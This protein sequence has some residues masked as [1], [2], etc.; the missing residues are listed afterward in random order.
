MTLP[1][2]LSSDR[3]SHDVSHCAG[4]PHAA[5][6]SEHGTHVVSV[7][8]AQPGRPIPGFAPNA[9]ARIFSFYRQG[10]DGQLLP[11]S[12]AGLALAIDSAVT[13]G[14]LRPTRACLRLAERPEWRFP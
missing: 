3:A 11:S 8:M 13:D 1:N 9:T 10:D 2:H 14:A 4:F 5:V 7:V 6:G 12:Q